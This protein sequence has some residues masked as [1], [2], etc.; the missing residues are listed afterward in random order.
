MSVIER[1]KKHILVDGFHVVVDLD[2]SHGSWVVD[3]ENGK[4]YLDCYSQFASQPLGWNYKPFLEKDT[5]RLKNAALYKIA[6]SDMYSEVYRD[7]V[8]TFA[9]IAPDF[10]HF[11]FIEGGALGV[12]NAL[13]AA[14]DW[15]VQVEPSLFIL[16]DPEQKLNIIHLKEA[17]HGRTGYTLSLTNTDEN[18]TKWFP[19]FDWTRAP[20]P[21]MVFPIKEDAL[22]ASE[23]TSLSIISEAMRH[24]HAAAII[25][26]T[27][28]GEGGDNHF[29]TSYL[30]AIRDLCN[31][32]NT[33]MILDEVQCGMG[34]TG[35]W[36]AYEHT[37]V[38]PDI[39]CFGKKSQVCGF[40]ST[41]RI[42][43][44]PEHVFKKSGRI[45]STWGGN[46]VDMERSR[47][48][49]EVVKERN[50]V[51]HAKLVGAHF[52]KEL[53]ELESIYFEVQNVR[54]RGLMLAFDLPTP[55]RRDRMIHELHEKGLL[56]LKSGERGIRFR[57]S[58]TF[59]LEDVF[60]AIQ[61]IKKTLG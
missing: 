49:I 13:K 59:S 57:P 42:E 6:N 29:R 34:L 60:D 21:K 2:K 48:M 40:A 9:S 55:E 31:E 47:L 27:I 53:G 16:D 32:Y 12:E 39:I 50:L 28:Q 3:A 20:N 25:L 22:A 41:N 10:K 44:A 14:F 33:L 36:W 51:N 61:I 45:N 18:K 52:L 19:K 54:G 7:F 35:E 8:E 26:E 11:F 17:F 37:G 4:R 15:K 5:S 56:A 46:F 30:K 43:K 58:L 38:V 23:R 24:T 1:L